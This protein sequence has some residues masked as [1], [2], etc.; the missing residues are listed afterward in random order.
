MTFLSIFKQY[1]LLI[2]KWPLFTFISLYFTL[3]AWILSPLLSAISVIF[4]VSTLPGIFQWFST[5]ND[6]LDGGQ[7][8][9]G[10]KKDVKGFRLWWQRTCWIC[11]NPAH[12]W[13]A[14][15]LGFKTGDF[16]VLYH[17]ES[18]KESSSSNKI[19]ISILKTADGRIWFAYKRDIPFFKNHYLKVWI[20]WND[21]PYGGWHHEVFQP[22]LFKSK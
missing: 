18:A 1:P 17:T 21:K 4:G 5:I 10:Y 11:R 22:F 8:Q 7:H 13:A 16:E 14:Y 15:L 2:I 12:G 9:V 3:L 6:D 19:S 20:G